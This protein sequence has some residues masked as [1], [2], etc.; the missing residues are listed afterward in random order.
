MLNR[1]TARVPCRRPGEV[2]GFLPEDGKP[3]YGYR[4]LVVY[5][6]ATSNAVLAPYH[7]LQRMSDLH[8]SYDPLIFPLLFPMGENGEIYLLCLFQHI[9]NRA[10]DT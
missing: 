9:E 5:P 6:R 10:C 7:G 4:E 8:P 3:K 1:P 2:A